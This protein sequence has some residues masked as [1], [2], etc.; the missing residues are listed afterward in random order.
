MRRY[1]VQDG[2]LVRKIRALSPDWFQR[3]RQRVHAFSRHNGYFEKDADGNSYKPFWNE[4]KDIYLSLQ[5]YK[6]VYC[7][8]TLDDIEYG[9]VEM[10]VEHYRPKQKVYAW[11]SR[12]MRRNYPHLNQ[13]LQMRGA[14][15]EGGYWHLAYHP[16][17]LAVSCIRCN[18]RVKLCYFPIAGIRATARGGGVS[19]R[20]CRDEDA[21][22]FYPIG[23]IDPDDPATCITFYGPF[24]IPAQGVTP[25][26][27]ERARITIDLLHLNQRPEL[28]RG[29]SRIIC[30]V[31]TANMLAL[32]SDPGKADI[33]H[34]Q[35]NLLQLTTE[36]HSHCATCF[37]H[38]CRT[39]P[40]EAAQIFAAADDRLR[41]L[42]QTS[43]RNYE[44]GLNVNLI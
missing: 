31:Y 30:A 37:L 44:V 21:D 17:N 24:A 14:A 39:N 1:P 10:E 29:R 19:P 15:L 23:N 20:Q 6:C 8:R 43:V 32:C 9:A 41:T 18:R 40:V 22:L 28:L 36:P 2:A 7:D 25:R 5:Q 26:C 42:K 13:Y 4:L 38:L 12:D 33:G 3:A 27:Q 34:N 35:L 16:L 11:P